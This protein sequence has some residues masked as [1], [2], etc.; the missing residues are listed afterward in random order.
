[1]IMGLF[2]ENQRLLEEKITLLQKALILETRPEERF[3]LE[4]EIKDLQKT[5]SLSIFKTTFKS[6]FLWVSM[7]LFVLFII[8]ILFNYFNKNSLKTKSEQP[9]VIIQNPNQGG[10]AIQ[11]SGVVNIHQNPKGEK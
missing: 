3:R 6:P 4:Q 9:T 1:M 7:G 8:L 2:E 11:G 10:I 5:S